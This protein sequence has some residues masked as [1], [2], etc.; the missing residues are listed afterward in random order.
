VTA[1]KK[2]RQKEMKKLSEEIY[3]ILKN[4]KKKARPMIAIGVGAMAI[5][6]AYSMVHSAKERCSECCKMITNVFKKKEK[7]E[8]S[9]AED[10]EC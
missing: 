3:M 5:Y 7:C 9:A 8:T 2:I 6:G 4:P 10:A 1:C